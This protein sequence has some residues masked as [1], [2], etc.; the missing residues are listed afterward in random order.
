MGLREERRVTYLSYKLAP[1]LVSSCIDFY[2]AH[3]VSVSCNLSYVTLTSIS[4][5]HVTPHVSNV[6]SA[7][8]VQEK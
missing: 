2:L 4:S 6:L 1:I 3:A 8:G 7:L 5:P